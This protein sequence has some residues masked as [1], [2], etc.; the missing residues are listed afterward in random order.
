[1]ITCIAPVR[2]YPTVVS[3]GNHEAPPGAWRIEF[4][5]AAG[6]GGLPRVLSAF[7]DPGLTYLAITRARRSARECRYELMT[8]PGARD[9]VLAALR[10]IN[11]PPESVRVRAHS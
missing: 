4:C 11:P 7:R 1:V 6:S 10:A 9:Q 2:P 8:R 3:D 5:L